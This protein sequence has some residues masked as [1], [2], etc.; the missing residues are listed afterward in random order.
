[1]GS[2]PLCR[3]AAPAAVVSVAVPGAEAAAIVA[4]LRAVRAEIA[5][6]A[7]DA[8]RD[9][10]SVT[11]VAV[12]KGHGP[13]AVRAAYADGQRVFGESYAH[14]LA[15][16]AEAVRD[17]V[18]LQWHFIGHLQRNKMAI[19]A[20]YAAIVHSLDSTRGVDALARC[21]AALGPDRRMD[22]LLQVNVGADP[23]KSGC[24]PADLPGLIDRVATHPN[25]RWRGLMTLPPQE[26]EP[27]PIFHALARLRDLERERVAALDGVGEG[28]SMGMSDDAGIAIAAGATWVRVGT[29]IFGARSV[30][31]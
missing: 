23:A 25:L 21:V 16:K 3:A 26:V 2:P 27:A 15:K 20:P 10:A 9:P 13:D 31:G 14:E 6:A 18:D 1:M 28:L 30:P 7:V 8:G 12:S 24:S 4:R 11:L 22:V 5:R 19:V 29:A 17:L